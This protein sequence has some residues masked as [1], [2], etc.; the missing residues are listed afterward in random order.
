MLLMPRHDAGS[1]AVR[2]TNEGDPKFPVS[3]DLA[4]CPVSGHAPQVLPP[5]LLRSNS[6]LSRSAHYPSRSPYVC[7]WL[8]YKS[9]VLTD[10]RQNQI[11]GQAREH[12]R[13]R[14]MCVAMA[15]ALHRFDMRLRLGAV[16][17][18][19]AAQRRAAAEAEARKHKP[20]TP[21]VKS[22]VESKAE[23]AALAKAKAAAEEAAKPAPKP[24]IRPLSESKAIES[25]A[26]F[27]S[28]AFLFM[29][30]GG[31]IVFESWR[32]RRKENT[33]REDVESR[34]IE[35][36]E[37]EKAARRG[38]AA[39]EKELLQQKAKYGDLSKTSAR[40]LPRDAWEIEEEEHKETPR[41]GWLSWAASY[42]SFGE[43]AEQQADAV[44]QGSK[45]AASNQPGGSSNSGP[46]VN[47]PAP[48]GPSR[49]LAP[50]SQKA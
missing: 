15:Q 6:R 22:E 23:E 17:D 27:I 1:S 47:T 39:L 11:K 8:S 18:T 34:L 24:H 21:T 37:S 29:V 7:P 4:S 30:A 33:R 46:P 12:E 42:F 20:T 43:T 31:L 41:Q 40:I 26:N 10:T 13:F 9:S 38:L 14:N 36:E 35:L 32:S 50:E 2:L 44:I 19:S 25:G 48:A 3:L 28:E 49:E 5:C 16:R 45:K